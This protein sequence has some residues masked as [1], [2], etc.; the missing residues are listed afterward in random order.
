MFALIDKILQLDQPSSVKINSYYK[1]L[2]YFEPFEI[3]TRK[4]EIEK[5]IVITMEDEIGN[6]GVGDTYFLNSDDLKLVEKTNPREVLLGKADVPEN[7]KL[8]IEMAYLDLIAR[9]N[10]MRF[11]SLFGEINREE[12]L[13]DVTI[14]IKPLE[15]TINEI[16][17]WTK[18]GFKVIKLK[19]GKGTVEEEKNKLLKVINALPSGVKLRIDANQG[20]N[21]KTA[22]EMVQ[23]ANDYAEIIEILEQPL[24]KDDLSGIGKLKEISRIPI[25]VDESIRKVGDLEKVE[26]YVDGINI[27]IS[28]ASSI[29]EAITLGL[30]AK[31]K[32]L[33]VMIG[34][35]YET[36]I[37]ITADAYIASVINVDYADLD[38]D[39]MKKDVVSKR[40]ADIRNSHRI[41]PKGYGLGINSEDLI[42]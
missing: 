31:Q 21:R 26:R 4:A 41:L 35:S 10:K 32:G 37:G 19:M 5:I 39:F 29:I 6:F 7:V 34:C 22:R 1:E 3:A 11:G 33:K 18:E 20:W 25:V 15:K 38:A 30:L 8:G 13:T 2:P 40:A 36:N 42:L 16:E 28:K 9:R 24:P 14:G 17:K 12:I 23:L 27:K